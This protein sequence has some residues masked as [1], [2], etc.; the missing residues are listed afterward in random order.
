M[1][2]HCGG[3]LWNPSSLREPVISQ[4]CGQGLSGGDRTVA[5]VAL[6]RPLN[7]SVT[8]EPLRPRLSESAL[9]VLGN[10]VL[11]NTVRSRPWCRPS[12]VPF[13]MRTAILSRLLG[14]IRFVPSPVPFQNH[15]GDIVHGSS[16]AAKIIDCSINGVTRYFGHGRIIAQ[17]RV[18]VEGSP[19]QEI[20]A[21]NILIATGSRSAPLPGVEVDGD[22]IGTSTEALQYPEVPG[23]LVV[24]G[25]GVI[26]LELAFKR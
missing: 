7:S 10:T 3:T 22:L 15:N 26:G 18:L 6:R 11:G 21:K 23:H 20:T 5:I 9:I 4:N 14:S 19:S 12:A 8:M 1:E 16:T 2:E 25:A 13:S 17:G 24:I